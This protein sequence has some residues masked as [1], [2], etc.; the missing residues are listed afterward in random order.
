MTKDSE[1]LGFSHLGT[2]NLQLVRFLCTIGCSFPALGSFDGIE[3]SCRVPQHCCKIPKPHRKETS[4]MPNYI[5]WVY[6]GNSNYDG[7]LCCVIWHF[8]SLKVWTGG[9]TAT[10]DSETLGFSHLGTPNL[11]LVRFLCTIGCSFPALGSFD[12][13]E[14]SCRVPQHCCKIPKPHRKETSAMPNYILW[15]YAGNSNYDGILCCV[16]WHFSSLKVWT[17]G[18]TATKDSETL[19]FSHLGTPNLQL[20]RFLCT[21]G[22]SFPALGSFDG[23][24]CSCRVPQHCCKIPKPHRKE[25][26]AMPNYILWVYAGNSNYDG[27]LCCVIWHFSSLKVWTEGPTATK[28]S[29]TLGFSHL[30][31]PNLQLVR[32]LCTIVCSFPALGSFDGIECSCRVPQ[33]CC[34]IPK[35]HRK[36]AS[37]M[38]NYI[39]WVYA[40]NSNYDGILC[41]VIW[42][43]SSLRVWTGGP[44]A[45]K[46][47]ETLGFS[48]LGTPNLQLVRFLCT[49]GCSFPALGSFDGVEC[50]CRVPQ[51]CCKI[52][53]P[54]GKR[55]Q[56]CQ[57]TFCG[58]MLGTVIMMESYDVSFGIFP[59]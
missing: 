53:N 44:T 42:H 57:I 3:C 21:I 25:A 23:I 18:P 56:Q 47:S 37:A 54:T 59:H 43:F 29:E 12:G 36:E 58:C 10:K 39:L 41:C 26:S 2:P 20:V 8:S 51:H 50:S 28:D 24:E 15:V 16:I 52:P 17:E 30:G 27:I 45:T 14:C 34:K 38:P 9:P 35:P 32:F 1:I 11:Q 4:A 33:H 55:P 13:I 48:H 5:L 22:C 7:I 31:T 46:D 6:A 40:G 49:I 19:G